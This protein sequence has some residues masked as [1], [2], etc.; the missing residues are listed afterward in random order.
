MSSGRP[1]LPRADESAIRSTSAG[2][3]P[4][5]NIGVATGPGATAFRVSRQRSTFA[6]I[7]VGGSTAVLVAE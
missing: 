1:S 5:R 6:R 2:S 4:S 3:F 7:I